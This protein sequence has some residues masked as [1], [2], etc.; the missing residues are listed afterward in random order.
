MD[1]WEK[2]DSLEPVAIIGMV[3]RFP[4]A[5]G[6][7]EFWRNL[8]QGVESISFFT[9][10]ELL[11]E[12]IDLANLNNPNYVRAASVLSDVDLF[13]A[14][15]FKFPPHEA[16]IID[17]QHRL[18]LEY[19]WQAL[20]NAG[21]N[22][23]LYEGRIGVYA[24]AGLNSYL[25][26]NLNTNPET[27]NF[28]DIYRL[29]VGNDKDFV[30]TRVSFQ[31]DLTGPS[32]NVSTA[33][34]TSLVAVQMGCQ[35]LLNYQADMVLAGGVS[36]HFPQKAGYFYQEGM[37][38]SP[39][40][41]CRAFDAQ[42][43]GTIGGSGVGIIV[44]KRLEDA[45]ADGD[46]IH[47]I[48]KG[49]AINNDGASKVGYTAPSIKGQASV[50]LEAQAIAGIDPETVTYIEAHGTGTPLG[51]PIEIA[52]L[53]QAFSASTQKKGFCGIGSVK[54]NV[55][56][57]DAASGVTSLIKT[58]LALK[59]K[60]IPPSL[61]FETPNPEIDFANSPF[62]VN[63]KLTPWE[64]NGMPRRAGVSSFGIGGTN[65]HVVLEEAPPG[66]TSGPSR[67]WQLLLLSA[68]T[69]SALDTATANLAQHLQ[70][71]LPL[72]DVAYT[73]SMGRKAFNH[74]RMLVC[75]DIEAATSTLKNLE[76]TPDQVR[77]HIQDHGARPVVFLFSGQ[78]TQYVNMAQELYHCE[79]T[80][81]RQVDI[82]CEL[83]KPHLG[84][85]LHQI[86]YPT[87]AQLASASEQLRQTAIAQ[88]A[89]FVIE[90]ALAQLWQEWGVRPRAMMGHSIGEYVAATLAGVW[91]LED[92]L[93]LVAVRG[94][95]M[96]GLPSGSMLAVPLAEAAVV[97]LL[98]Q[99]LSLAVING[100]SACVVSGA[101]EAIEAFER[102]LASQG[103]EGRRL[104]TSHAFHSPMMEPI[105]ATFTERVKQVRLSAPQIPYLSNVTGTWMTAEEATSPLYWAKHLRQPVRWASGLATLLQASSQILL[106]LG[107]GRSLTTL[108]KRHPEKTPEQLVVSCLRHPQEAGSDVGFLLKT[109]GQ[110]WLAGVDI[111]WAG[112]Y[113][114]ERR[115][116]LPLPTYPFERQRYWVDPLQPEESNGSM[117]AALSKKSDIADW[118]YLPF[119]K[120]SIPPTPAK[121]AVFDSSQ[122]YTLVFIEDECGLGLRLIEG[123]QAQN[124]PVI[125]VKIGTEF[126]QLV[127]G[128]YALNPGNSDDYDALLKELTTQ[129]KLPA[130][131]VHLWNISAD[132]DIEFG[133]QL[134]EQAQ[135]KGFY[136]L[137]FLA[138]ALGKQKL[139]KAVQLTVISNNLQSVTREEKLLP[140]KATLLGPVKVIPQEYPNIS[141]CSI[142]VVLSSPDSWQQEKLVNQLLTELRLPI[143]ER[144]LAYRGHTRWV[145]MFE[146]VQLEAMV[147][148]TPRLRKGGG[149]LITG[150][151]GGVGL[152]LAQYLAETV[153]AKLVL[154]GRSAFPVREE[155][156][157]WLNTHE[158]TDST[159]RKIRK[160]QE[161][162]ALGAEVLV[163][164]ADVADL[165]QMRDAIAQ[166]QHQLGS[167]HGVI[168]AAGIVG[169]NSFNTIA[170]LSKTECEQQFRPKVH[171]LLVLEQVLQ[172]Q[173]LDFCLLMSSLASIL[174]GL[175]YVAYGAANRFMDAFTLQHNQ[176]S[177]TPWLS[178]NWDAW[179]VGIEKDENALNRTNLAE[180][181]FT[182]EEGI[183][184]FQRILSRREFY[185]QLVVS[186]GDLQSRLKK[187][188]SQKSAG[189]RISGPKDLFH[190]R[191]EL[192]NAYVAPRNETEQKLVNIWQQVLGLEPIGIHDNFFELGGDSLIGVQLISQ[193]RNNFQLEVP[194]S[195][196]FEFPCIADLVL[197]IEEKRL[198][199][200]DELTEKT[201][202]LVPVI[203]RRSSPGHAPL[204][205]AQQRL[206]FL[207]QLNPGSFNYN[208][209][210]DLRFVGNLDIAVLKQSLD[211]IVRRHEVL[212]TTFHVI[213]GQPVQVIAPSLNLKLS[214]IN[215]C[216]LP[217]V[218]RDTEVQ[219]LVREEA[220]KPFDL[221]Q[222]PLL[223]VTLLKIDNNEDA[224]L[225]TTHHIVWDGWSIGILMGELVALYKAFYKGLASP[226]PELPL[227]YADFAV[228][229]RNWLQGE[230]LEEKLNYW[231]QQIGNN[232]PILQLPTVRPRSEVKTSRGATQSFVISSPL[233]REIKLLSRQE[234]VSLF[235]TLLAAFQILLQRYTKQDDI[236]VGTD[237]A[238]RGWAEIEPLIGFFMNLLVLRTDMG[239]NPSFR[240]F[241]KRVREVVLGAYDHQDLP[242]E[243]LVEAL[244]PERSRS[245]MPLFQASFVLQN[246]SMPVF[247]LPGV[248][249]SNSF[250][251]NDT[252]RSDLTMFLMETDRGIEGSWRYNADLFENITIRQ[253]SVHFQTLLKSIARQPDS[254]INRLEMRTDSEREQQSANKQQRKASKL[255]KLMTMKTEAVE[256]PQTKLTKTDYLD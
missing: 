21:Y 221:T 92:A 180:F 145:Q 171:G 43:Q 162:E 254:R 44:L 31:L 107:P 23:E 104:H 152:V 236:V 164:R 122:I 88:P 40:G 37:I 73:L 239:G 116:R 228:W 97:P 232:L 211:E 132:S 22:S 210:L 235:T 100:P 115:H 215:L 79:A 109:V 33:C 12:G 153:Q 47:A 183:Q 29:L 148:E 196:L 163:L 198:E 197:A 94:Q 159:S 25:L 134:I 84:L 226:L 168:H 5:E 51:D 103:I 42:A 229:Q 39:D 71:E 124:Q 255:K 223:R 49:S 219:R 240:E 105:L 214:V 178:I 157:S 63:T 247:E 192:Q 17:P 205:F 58:V 66:E 80:F 112:F 199:K 179:K 30:A 7:D 121:S 161:L 81:A 111:D 65:A 138:Q 82:C 165:A 68:K 86:L 253:M 74:R 242:F 156:S 238:N 27:S 119:W 136:S 212:R 55:G 147:T 137:L 83:L 241:L 95:L 125:T 6:V 166:A 207:E 176:F 127:E 190:P 16:E 38:L 144:V 8:Q 227:Q 26:R 177:A 130:R 57:L 182:P 217:K 175:G 185:D 133:P 9:D 201:R 187:W 154:I 75:Q 191:P 72:A 170:Q 246:T 1:K 224:V 231:K 167:L 13:D 184:A 85:D 155:W 101:T 245:Q 70:G 114:Q 141:C 24:G 142:D 206:W 78:G 77:T 186:T 208:E 102:Q 20:E 52:A 64:T 35:S 62:Y 128:L 32:V 189:E 87:A 195:H 233:S 237:V 93:A 34:S 188:I 15:F 41:H 45:L 69:S 118:F 50:I 91:S 53:T 106:E 194:V 230:V 250:F 46:C 10:E 4:G 173:A 76:D 2:E 172:G 251:R 96:Q 99:D 36:V 150:G 123:L 117:P 204:S 67:P 140:V 146:P 220:Q 54:T 169:G 249:L 181:V 110:L 48:I 160:V 60:Q 89:L 158:E 149:Y 225:I 244:Q 120:P 131:I 108:A 200:P 216:E 113:A 28:A 222:G 209:P 61:H 56:H 126:T 11:A 202:R 90:Y 151:L 218:A 143:S 3:G 59:H 213:D 203:P 256:L 139:S 98:G 243:K 18:F 174:G 234:G 19:A 14:S 252:A 248:T 135:E 193:I 129:Q